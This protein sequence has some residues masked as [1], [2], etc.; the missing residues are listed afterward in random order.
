MQRLPSLNAL[1]AFEAAARH[2]S[3]TKAAA[4][5]S[6]TPAAI[7]HQIKALEAD[8]GV[9]LMRRVK[10]EFVLTAAAEGALPAL[11]AGFDQIAEAA[12]RLREDDTRHLLTISVGPTF[13]ATWLVRRLRDLKALFPDLDVR[14][15]TTDRLADFARDG[16][17]VAIRFGS[18]NYP[19][20]ESFRLFDEAVFPVC[21]PDLLRRGPPVG[22]P[23]DLAAHTLL[24]TEWTPNTGE[25]FDWQTWLRAAGAQRVDYTRGPRFTHAKVALEAAIDGQGIALGSEAL[26]RDDIEAGHLVRLFDF[27]LPMDFAYHL[28]YPRAAAALPKVAAFRKWIL[29][30]TGAAALKERAV[31]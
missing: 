20:L 30:E 23:S 27:A 12:R 31:E 8:L 9:A 21:S 24:H 18:G 29:A 28:V 26:A 6:V 11:R 2:R 7:S 16:V 17:D 22:T 13:A 5:L 1:R 10:N 25:T 14:L 4:E 3:L 15:A 19:G